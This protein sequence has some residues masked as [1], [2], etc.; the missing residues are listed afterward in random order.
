MFAYF[1]ASCF[2]R[3]V[4][5]SPQTARLIIADLPMAVARLKDFFDSAPGEMIRS[6]KGDSTGALRR[7]LQ[8]V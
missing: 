4:Q 5:M 8:V 7:E 6:Q 2:R 3:L 1:V